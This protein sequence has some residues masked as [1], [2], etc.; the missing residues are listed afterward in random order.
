MLLQT[1]QPQPTTGSAIPIGGDPPNITRTAAV[2]SQIN[3]SRLGSQLSAPTRPTLNPEKEIMKGISI[4]YEE[5]E[6]DD[7][8]YDDES[9][10]ELSDKEV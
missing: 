5:E 7:V 8:D 6:E 4:K 10:E 2:P 3:A 9:D 1:P